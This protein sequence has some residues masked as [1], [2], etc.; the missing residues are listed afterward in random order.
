[1]KALKKVSRKRRI[2]QPMFEIVAG[3]KHY[4]VTNPRVIHMKKAPKLTQLFIFV[5]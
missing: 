4:V 5:L 3:L 2:A 1:M